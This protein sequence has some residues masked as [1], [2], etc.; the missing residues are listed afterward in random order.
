MRT[1]KMA[2]VGAGVIGQVHAQCLHED[3][4]IEFAA[5]VDI[6][7]EAAKMLAEKYGVKWFDSVEKCLSEMPEIEA[8]DI[9]VQ[10]D[11]H[12][13]PAV[14]IANSGKHILLEKPIAKTTEEALEIVEAAEKN[15]VRLL[16]A[17]LLHYDARYAQLLETV[18]SGGLGEIS[19]IFVRRANTISTAK[20]LGGKVSYMYYLGVHDIEMMCAYANGGR[21]IRAYAQTPTKV[22]EKYGDADGMYGIVNFDNG[23][24]GCF[25]IDWSTPDPSPRPV[26]SV[27]R[28]AGTKGTGEV[29]A[30]F[31]GLTIAANNSYAKAD[32]MLSPVFNGR[33]HGDMPLQISHFAQSILNDTPFIVNLQ[34][35]VDAVRIIDACFESVSTGQ[36]VEIHYK[37]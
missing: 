1:L 11:F 33:M 29:D 26:W 3:P 36:S 13:D 23:V 34:T 22:C 18:Q 30:D 9:C 32:T 6:R 10:E 19:H 15:G 5:V 8:Y 7:P 25:E 20:R 14:T 24:V 28:V 35:P 27:A 17:H 4:N 2:L 16:I 21:P 31:Y 37:K 12:V